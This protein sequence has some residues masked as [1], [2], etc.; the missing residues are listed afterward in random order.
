MLEAKIAECFNAIDNWTMIMENYPA[1][2]D[3][4]GRQVKRTE[5]EIF[6][7]HRAIEEEKRRLAGGPAY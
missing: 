3:T 6:T 7:L 4:L 1:R 5:G 2:S